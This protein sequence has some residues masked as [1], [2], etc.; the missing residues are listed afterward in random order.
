MGR[1]F[2]PGNLARYRELASG[3]ISEIE[4][5]QL[6]KELAEEMNAFRRESHGVSANS[7]PGFYEAV[8]SQAAEQI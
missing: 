3:T 5:R 7:R 8:G 1:F 4:Q 2:S 6:L